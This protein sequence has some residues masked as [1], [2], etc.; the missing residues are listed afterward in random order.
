MSL[1]AKFPVNAFAVGAA[2]LILSGCAVV[3]GPGAPAPK[4]PDLISEGKSVTAEPR[5][6][7]GDD[8]A[9]QG[10]EDFPASNVTDGFLGD[11]S[12]PHGWSFWLAAEDVNDASVTIDLGAPY[13]ITKVA[14]QDTH[15]RWWHDRGTKDFVVLTASSAAGPFTEVGRGSF[16]ETEW[17]NL[18][19][20]D[21]AIS[22]AVAQFV[23]VH[24]LN[25][26]GGRSV[27]LNEVQVFGTAAGG[28]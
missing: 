19:V 21:V 8:T 13:K 27:G 24:A 23:R 12:T 1:L 9:F 18:T 15:N 7:A 22:G 3:A 5:S 25:G 10:G 2:C 17:R 6:Y 14:V 11:G 20:K 28:R 4:A 26:W 16:S